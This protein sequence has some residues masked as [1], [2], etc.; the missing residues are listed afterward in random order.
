[1]LSRMMF[2]FTAQDKFNAKATG[3]FALDKSHD[4]K[5]IEHVSVWDKSERKGGT[6]P[7]RLQV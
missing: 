5:Q 6:L 2:G 3:S 7:V 1:M 4:E